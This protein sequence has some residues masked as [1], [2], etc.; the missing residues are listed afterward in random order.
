MTTLLQRIAKSV[1]PKTVVEAVVICVVA[2]FLS[3]ILIDVG[4]NE[5][6][7]RRGAADAHADIARG[8]FRYNLRGMTRGWDKNL[9]HM[10]QRDYAIQIRRTGGCACAGPD[11]SYDFAYN[12]VVQVHLTQKFGFDPID[13]VFERARAEWQMASSDGVAALAND[14]CQQSPALEPA[15]GPVTHGKSSPPTQ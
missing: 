6:A 11:C 10:A 14:A 4:R 1:V 9:I 5:L 3:W 15:A 12:R 2:G 13:R 8:T 7:A